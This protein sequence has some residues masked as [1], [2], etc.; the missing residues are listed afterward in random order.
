MRLSREVSE[1]TG[2]PFPLEALCR[3]LAVPRSSY[4]ESLRRRREACAPRERRRPGPRVQLDDAA[5]LGKI[6]EVL[7]ETP[8]HT[9]GHKKVRARLRRR[10]IRA[11]RERVNRVMRRAGLLSPQRAARR[12]G[13]AHTGSIVPKTINE[14]W[15]TDGT[16]FGTETGALL[17]LF[18][19]IDHYSD[20]VLGWH[21]VEVGRGDR[22]AA[23]E[24]LKLALRRVRGAVAKDVGAEIAVRHDWGPQYRSGDFKRELKYWGLRNSPALV[25]EPET[26]GVIERFFRTLKEECLWVERFADAEEARRIVGRWIETYNRHWLIER[27]G[28]RTPCEVRE[29]CEAEAE[30]A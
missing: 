15:G 30:A 27:H 11:G 23:L 20:E 21:I 5:L 24:P 4:Y 22:F 12:E 26:N 1:A 19:V 7:A 2:R 16:L 18:A 17:W 13:K 8:F 29:R 6:R 25:H 14:L 10:G 9:E 3:L 28:Y